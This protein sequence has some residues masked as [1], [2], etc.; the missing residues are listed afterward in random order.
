MNDKRYEVSQKQRQLEREVRYAKRDAAIA[1]ATKDKE[2]FADQSRRVKAAQAK[3]NAFVDKNGL[4]V[5]PDRTQV[6]EY[7]KSVA[8]KAKGVKP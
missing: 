5:R 4:T 6:P 8:A 2:L 7:N 3:M 1:D